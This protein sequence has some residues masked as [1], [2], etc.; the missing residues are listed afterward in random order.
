MSQKNDRLL[1]DISELAKLDIGD[2]SFD[3]MKDE[4]DSMIDFVT[5]KSLSF[6]VKYQGIEAEPR[7]DIEG[8]VLDRNELLSSSKNCDGE[9]F[10]V[11]RIV[12]GG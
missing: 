1:R 3:T 4:M 11:P 6:D 12:S 8:A 9:Y 7:K 10:T 5:L 2:C